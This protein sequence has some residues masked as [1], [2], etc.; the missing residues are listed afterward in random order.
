[1]YHSVLPI[2]SFEGSNLL[3]LRAAAR[4]WLLGL[5]ATIPDTQRSSRP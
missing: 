2:W 1:M 4:I 5:E 3:G